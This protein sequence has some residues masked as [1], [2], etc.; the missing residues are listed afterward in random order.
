ME[1]PGGAL[2]RLTAAQEG[3]WFAQRL[4]RDETAHWAVSFVEIHGPVDVDLF[5]QAVRQLL[6]EDGAARLRFV[7]T[8]D[9]IRQRFGPAAPLRVVDISHERDPYAAMRAWIRD[10]LARPVDLE[11][12][13]NHATALFRAAT[14][15]FYWAEAFHHCLH[16]AY[17]NQLTA[18][19]LAEI[20]TALVDGEPGTGTPLPAFHRLVDADQAYR[21][22]E[23][24]ARD[25]EFWQEELAGL[26]EPV[27]LT[28]RTA[29]ASPTNVRL[30]VDL[31][32]EDATRLRATAERV[33]V[34]W[35]AFAIAATAQY[36]YRM[37]GSREI[38]L[39]LPVANRTTPETRSIPGTVSNILPLRLTVDPGM[40]QAAFVRHTA[41]RVRLALRHQRYPHEQMVR[42]LGIVNQ[43][44]RLFGPQINIISYTQ[45]IAFAGHRATVRHDVNVVDDVHFL[46]QAAGAG[47]RLDVDANPALYRADEIAGHAVRFTRFL[48]RFAAAAPDTPVS[49]IPLL[50]ED[51][52][53]RTLV[54]W[55]DTAHPVPAATLPE[56]FAAQVA[57]TPDAV[58]VVGEDVRWTF[59]EL[60]AR[61]DRLARVLIEKGV[62]PESLVA[63]AMDRSVEMV[64]VLLAVLKA[65][66]AYVPVDPDQPAA[67]VRH[68]LAT[69]RPALLI[70][71]GKLRHRLPDDVDVA[72]LVVDAPEVAGCDTA[73]LSDTDRV[74]P[75]LPDHPAYV[76]FTSGSTGVPKGVAVAHR[77]VVNRLAWMQREY[78]LD[79]S[80]RVLHKTPFGFDVSVWELFW[81][82]L[83]GARLV[84]A[85]PG[86]HRDPDYLA[87]LIDRQQITTVHFVPSML[88][89]FLQARTTTQ[90]T[91]LRRVICSGEAL[92]AA[93]ATRAHQ[94]LD[95]P[96]H[97]LYG[98]TEATVDVTFQPCP[99]G[100]DGTVPI[101]RPVWNTRVFVLDESLRPVPPGV[102]GELYLA[103]VQLARG[104]HGQPGLTGERFVACP[105]ATTPGE[106][107]Y[108]TGDV[109]RWTADGVVEFLGRADEQVKIRGF[110]IE[111]GEIEA[112]LAAHENVAQAT[113][114][115]REDAP[116][117]KRLVAYVVPAQDAGD[118]T[119][120]LREHAAERL[121]EYMVPSA[122]VA[123]DALPL[124]VNGKLDRGA[125]PAPTYAADAST[126]R[127]PASPREEILCG[128]FAEVLGLATVGAEDDFFHLGGHSL[129]ATR[130]I[131]RVRSLLGAELTV[132][133][134][135][136]APTVAGL[137]KRCDV[138]GGVRPALRPWQERPQPVPLSYAQRRLWFL[139]RLEGPSPTYNI[140]LAL[141][142]RGEVDQRALD[143]ALTDVMARHEALRTVFP[144]RDGV[145]HQQ[146]QPAGAVASVLHVVEAGQEADL[147]ELVGEAARY[148]FDLSV[149]VPLRVTLFVA[150]AREAVLLLLLH[151]VAGD[152][153]STAP[154]ARDLSAA[155][156][157]RLEGGAP[158]WTPL[159][160]QYID[161]TLWQRDLLGEA[162]RSDSLYSRQLEFWRRSLEGAPEQLVL[163]ADRPRPAVASYRGATVEVTLDAQLHEDLL[164]LARSTQTSLFMV[165]QAAFAT[166]LTR[167][168]AGEDIPVGSPIAG[169]T[170]EALDDLV[171]FFV[172]TLVLRTDTSG[173]PTFLEL[174]ERVR[175][176]DLAA[177]A[178][179]DLPFEHLV[180]KLNP[181]RSLAHHPLFQ[182]ILALQN[183]PS[184]TFAFPG[185]EAT[186]AFPETRTAK[187]D[188]FLSL[189]ER[190][191][192]ATA[193]PGGI[194]GYIEYALDLFD[195]ATVRSLMARF[196]RL[197]TSVAADPG[198]P[199]GRLEV[200]T[201]RERQQVLASWNDTARA[202]APAT[203]PRLFEA[204]AART[205]EAIAV[206]AAD[207][208]W[209]YAELDARANRLARHLTG[210]G[211]GPEVRVAVV[212]DR[213]VELVA[214]LLAVL[215]AGGAYVP[216]DPGQPAART[217]HIFDTAQPALLITS[218]DLR[219]RLPDTTGVPRLVIDD[220]TV[221]ER[222]AQQPASALTDAERMWPLRAEHPAYVIYTSGSTGAPKGVVVPHANVTRLLEAARERF[223][224][225]DGDVWTWF[226]SYAFDF[227][228]WELY[229]ALLSGGRLVVV[230]FDTSRSPL[231]FRHLLVRERVTILSQTPSAFYQ[232]LQAE[233]RQTPAGAGLALRLVVFG[234]EALDPVRLRDWYARHRDDAPAL[235]NMYGI[236]ETTVHVTAHQLDAAVAG[237]GSLASTVGRPLDNT[238]V[239]VLDERLV[240]VPPWV[241]GELYVA[242]AGLARGYLGQAGLTGERFVACP[243]ATVPG[244]RMYRTGD[245]VRWTPGGTLEFVGRADDQVKVRG[246]RI[247]PGEIEAV[248]REHPGVAQA[249]VVVREDRPGDQRLVGYVVP[250]RERGAG[251]REVAA[252]QVREWRGVYDSLYAGAGAAELGSDFS[253]WNSSYDSRPIPVAEM[254]EWRDA[255]V[256]RVR[257]LRPRRVLEVGVGTGLLLAELAP[258]CEEYWGTDLSAAVVGALRHQV[259]ADPALAGRVVLRHQAADVVDGLPEEYF[260]TVVINSV[261]QYFPDAEYLAGV[262]EGL[263]PLVRPGGAIFVGDVRNLRLLRL[264]RSAVEAGRTT[265]P[266]SAEALRQAVERSVLLEKEL[267][268]DPGFFSALAGRVPGLSG[269]DVRIKRGRSVTELTRYRYDAV[270][271][272]QAETVR[273]AAA[274]RRLRWGREVGDLR[275][276]E[277][278][279]SGCQVQGPFRVTGVPNARLAGDIAAVADAVPS[280]DAVPSQDGRAE[281]TAPDPETFHETGARHGCEVVV[282]WSADR[283]DG[284]LDIVVFPTADTVGPVVDL[285][286]SR[287]DQGGPPAAYTNSPSV[288]RLAGELL[289]AVRTWTGERLPEYMVP[290]A[291]VVLDSLPLTVNGKL[292]R[293][294][295][296]AP[297]L[298]AGSGRR[299]ASP[300]E[301]I[302]CGA[303]AEVL[304][305]TRVGMD[306]NFFDLGGHS[307]LATRLISRVRAL[308]GTELTVRDLFD[309]ST[310]ATLAE[311]L[312]VSGGVRPPVRPRQ[313]RPYPIPLSYAQRRLWFLSRLEGPSATYNIV[314]ALRMRGEV[315][316]QALDA[317]LTDVVTRH[318]ALRTVF[319]EHDGLPCQDIVDADRARVELTVT[320]VS[321]ADLDRAVAREAGYAFDLTAEL[322]VRAAL[323]ALSP[324][325]TGTGEPTDA[326]GVMGADDEWVLVVVV[327]H[328]AGDGWSMGPLWRDLSVA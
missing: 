53:H 184:G 324:A 45:D 199:I 313:E 328:I 243:F 74:A 241:A 280:V 97:N 323:F 154:L 296:P 12:G 65:G 219:H 228:V 22:S 326:A 59:G 27:S 139:S 6:A 188:L 127:G 149:D 269:A 217:R 315:D 317:A 297:D 220:P 1:G 77:G 281:R 215:K 98:P 60:A 305:L 279:L 275:D 52:R 325:D 4:A 254:V 107:M 263:L 302:L 34:R 309:A 204:Q 164:A 29:S 68:I 119:Q 111:P 293:R 9:G 67:R 287:A 225:D 227:S 249:A 144:E 18:G 70:T 266:R 274:T 272:K 132:R 258:S 224:F 179:Q 214:V 185:I 100:L 47:L 303:F 181:A 80:D 7:E 142:L 133:D 73:P 82:L 327:H 246:F 299:P 117:D 31:P 41:D 115:V 291:V 5:D 38:V 289:G 178:H 268:I 230:P 23:A 24:Y 106:R 39:G 72:R 91:S 148:P 177:W 175:D 239:F 15:H 256:D 163:P 260:D 202:I 158:A 176:T 157:A 238:R 110:R 301:E 88:P 192:P 271:Y 180:E 94:Q 292:D 205:P 189:W 245:V 221:A 259:D 183:A 290:S 48:S 134:L 155:Y 222:L 21:A 8:P 310:P 273:S 276:F 58:A 124:T 223:G 84:I 190:K 151:H 300:T 33:G 26:P 3:M 216:I 116:G 143:A 250:E 118:L 150:G 251:D 167:M 86:G 63:V 113:V 55:N 195:E 43:D 186:E 28:S 282:T 99:A 172:N 69:A 125:L 35:S 141:R 108:R 308:L 49:R 71:T 265:G 161:Y 320:G 170:D 36:L 253:G 237:E 307:L 210:L 168:G 56:L 95:T 264:F 66:G 126:G 152:G 122:V 96:L 284:A 104:Y 294:A 14:D 114:V 173:D 262:L 319:P 283:S 37:T 171:G 153:W 322:P 79:Q 270:L 85:R 32:A 318:E 120:R 231:E 42:D 211:V 248:L 101:G 130:L 218:H 187:F 87:E 235:V 298:G 128:A 146:V 135:F 92:P 51:E 261:V 40:G 17:A 203:L 242:G 162:S 226:H 64:A 213:S 19:R 233:A 145:P 232:L 197:L 112:V 312:D 46:I 311:R 198:R 286:H 62:G 93:L 90:C 20:Y 191:D 200:L 194:T 57:R 81:P 30:T 131:S 13:P 247:E 137:A 121:P 229:G 209:S 288:S 136:D 240:P 159:P 169:R 166:L 208:R 212:M 16:D 83:Q 285:Y 196:V 193:L 140:P 201:P 61:S 105:F 75:L 50:D 234:G 160:V 10:D 156:A 244:E 78:R 207:A 123:L 257:S 76:M 182:V 11:H 316:Q 314:L 174:L 102:P 252:E 255:T 2:L 25:R 267:L 165:L 278:E 103:G 277:R 306:D 138:S 321:A 304:G 206:V 295:L 129:L 147:R 109:V 89:A 44:R 236:T 54:E